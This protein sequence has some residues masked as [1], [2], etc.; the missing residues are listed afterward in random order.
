VEKYGRAADRIV[1]AITAF[2]DDSYIT[3]KEIEINGCI[4]SRLSCWLMAWTYSPY[5]F[6]YQFV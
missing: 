1:N 4:S 3:S 5:N 2:A 6:H